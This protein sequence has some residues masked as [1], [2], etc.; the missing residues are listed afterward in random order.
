MTI[1]FNTRKKQL[2]I[3]IS[4][5]CLSMSSA[6]ASS[7]G[8]VTGGNV[9]IVNNSTIDTCA[10]AAGESIVIMPTGTL[11][12]DDEYGG[13]IGVLVSNGI[14]AGVINN[15]GVIER[16]SSGIQLDNGT[17]V[18]GITNASNAMITTDETGI[19]IQGA[20]INGQLSNAGTINART[21]GIQI[22]NGVISQ[23][24]SNTGSISNNENDGIGISNSSTI[25]GGI[26]NGING[27]I[28]SGR[29]GI[30]VSDS[31]VNGGI[32]NA[33]TIDG[34]EGGAV[35]IGYGG[36]ING[37][38]TNT[39][40]LR[41]LNGDAALRLTGG[42]VNGKVLNSGTISGGE[43]N[44]GI[45]VDD[46]SKITG[47]IVNDVSGSILSGN[48]GI[49]VLRSDIGGITNAG[50]IDGAEG[51]P[52]GMGIVVALSTVQ[53]NITNSGTINAANGYAI[54]IQN[55]TL[56]GK[57][58][59]SGT[60]SGL[61]AID[62]IKDQVP[63]SLNAPITIDNSGTLDGAVTLADSILN[64]NGNTARV[65]GAVQGV[66]SVV[67]VNGNFS[68]QNTFDVGTFNVTR[69]GTFNAAYAIRAAD[70]LNNNGTLAVKANTPFTVDGNYVQAADASFRTEVL[71][72]TNYGQMT[73]NGTAVLAAGT[74]ID[75]RVS[76]L[77]TLA[78]NTV[79]AGIIKA[80]AL[81][82]STFKVTDDSALFNFAGVVNGN[83]VD[84]LVS[85]ASTVYGSTVDNRNFVGAG[86]ARELDKLIAGSNGNGDMGTVVTALGR[87][88][89]SKQ[90]SDAVKQ[91]L[92]LMTGA[93][94][95]AAA[96]AINQTGR[97]VQARQDSNLG[98]STGEDVISDKQ[99]WAK[100]FGSWAKQGDRNGVSGF[101]ARTGGLVVGA[102]GVLTEHD[103]LGAAFAYAHTNVSGN[104]SSTAQ[105]AKIDS[106][107]AMLYGSH[108]IDERTELSWQGDLGLNRTDGERGI[109]FG[110]LNRRA[111]SN[112][113]GWSAHVGTGVARVFSLN[114]AISVAPSLRLDYTSLTTRGYTE[115][116]AGA[117]NLQVDSQRTEELIVAAESKLSYAVA[118]DTTIVA[119]LGVGYNLLA[120]S[121]QIT[122]TFVGGGSA[123]S[124]EGLEP[125]PWTLRGGAGLILHR[126]G[127]TEVT[128][129][130][131]AE[132]NRSGF[133]N[134]TVSLKV[135]QSF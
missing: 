50:L 7:C 134:Q 83:N 101:D 21:G 16:Q 100:P 108:S 115:T 22:L 12:R 11:A 102:D 97:I 126:Q 33:G 111:T 92:P 61:K 86:A 66:G 35:H 133:S 6:F 59:N 39:G 57:I 109:N 116:G 125:S 82:A 77:A 42:T 78:P 80:T 132:A 68:A 40:I 71:S 135:R 79:L 55:S 2:A 67:N 34:G 48:I 52:G 26:R 9:T 23:G 15:Q 127:G 65:T 37:N 99:I 95:S 106:Y 119:N 104:D 62:I 94:A 110:G 84:L 131:D 105:S 47:E 43:F 20:T 103:R 76:S 90:V 30:M 8:G 60:L 31:T 98:L 120:K 5:A 124:T 63:F 72:A 56:N 27:T 58:I 18:T 36:I 107:Q 41:N 113:N 129:R 88:S 53:G 44:P 19:L 114:D 13:S 122:S 64:L 93:T 10:L 87:L 49:T 112:Y 117:L 17:S 121:A 118:A 28:Q 74:G 1:V 89:N 32:S 69:G 29:A 91:T 25:T 128:A 81:Q 54:L 46:S 3:L 4:T 123:F 96:A 75:V 70:G 38:I 51:G 45:F 73:V 14:S 24:I 130:Y 85:Q